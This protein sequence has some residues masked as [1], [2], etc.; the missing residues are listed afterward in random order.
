MRL[1]DSLL[2]RLASALLVTGLLP[3][4][5]QHPAADYSRYAY[6]VERN[7]VRRAM[8]TCGY[9]APCTMVL[10]PV[11]EAWGLNRSGPMER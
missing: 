11:D 7:V 2:A 8:V 3:A 10:Y 4:A 1:R 6:V 5:A 9:G